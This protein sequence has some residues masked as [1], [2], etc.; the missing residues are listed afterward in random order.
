MSNGTLENEYELSYDNLRKCNGMMSKILF[1]NG[2]IKEM[3]LNAF[4]EDEVILDLWLIINDKVVEEKVN[5]KE[6][7]NVESI[8]YSHPRWGHAP[9]TKFEFKK[10]NNEKHNNDFLDESGIPKIFKNNNTDNNI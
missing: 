4:D 10:R 2:S 9:Y 8:L 1:K 5:Y 7:D 6:I 3:Y